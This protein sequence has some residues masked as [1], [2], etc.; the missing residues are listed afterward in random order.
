VQCDQQAELFPQAPVLG[1]WPTTVPVTSMIAVLT[2]FSTAVEEAFC[3]CRVFEAG[4]LGLRAR[5]CGQRQRWCSFREITRKT[6]T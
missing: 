4:P 1:V 2:G 3:G 5:A 6:C